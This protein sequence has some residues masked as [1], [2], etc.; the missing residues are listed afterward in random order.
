MLLAGPEPTEALGVFVES[1]AALLFTSLFDV[2]DAA[3]KG[4]YAHAC[5]VLD[6]L[7]EYDVEMCLECLSRTSEDTARFLG[8]V[9]TCVDQPSVASMLLK[10]GGLAPTFPLALHA[11]PSKLSL[12][13]AARVAR[14]GS[15]LNSS[16][17]VRKRGR[18]RNGSSTHE[19]RS[20]AFSPASPPSLRRGRGQVRLIPRQRQRRAAATVPAFGE[21]LTT[22]RP[23]P[24]LRR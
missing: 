4:S 13:A 20:L 5:H 14:P 7:I 1:R 18:G 9:V 22:A 16:C 24:P 11:T 6:C 15:P 3:S 21:W 8:L 23:L 19:S 12:T 2:F 17:D 10:V